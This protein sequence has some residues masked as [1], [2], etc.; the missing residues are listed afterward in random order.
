MANLKSIFGHGFQLG[1]DDRFCSWLPYYHDMGLVG[2]ILA[3]SP[4]SIRS[5]IWHP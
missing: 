4:R 5:T 1:D 3:A 2:K